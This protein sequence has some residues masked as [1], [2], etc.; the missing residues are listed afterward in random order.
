MVKK[1]SPRGSIDS[2]DNADKTTR[3]N[4]HCSLVK[5]LLVGQQRYAYRKV[6]V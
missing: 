6:F 2:Q 1:R 4:E 5:L 3:S